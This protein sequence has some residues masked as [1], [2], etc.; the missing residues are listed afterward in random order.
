MGLILGL[1]RPGLEGVLAAVLMWSM[2]TMV[3]M[4]M[5]VVVVVV[6]NW[7]HDSRRPHLW[8]K[9]PSLWS[10]WNYQE[11][12][13]SI[14]DMFDGGGGGIEGWRSFVVD[15]G[16]CIVVVMLV[17]VVVVVTWDGESEV[18]FM[19]RVRELVGEV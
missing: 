1:K 7:E 3:I 14:E 19:M 13:S 8:M 16:L 11:Q 6:K 12:E 17:V 10:V 9:F 4:V 15:G 2:A 18:G 5:V